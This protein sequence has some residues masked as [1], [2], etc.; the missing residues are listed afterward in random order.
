MMAEL[1]LEIARR[2]HEDVRERQAADLGVPVDELDW[3]IVVREGAA[4]MLMSVDTWREVLKRSWERFAV[5][6]DEQPPAGTAVFG[7]IPIIHSET[8]EGE[9]E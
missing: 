9:A 1:T 4:D 6:L 2:L 7:G 5:M 3:E 8:I